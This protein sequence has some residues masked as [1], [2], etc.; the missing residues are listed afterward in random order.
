VKYTQYG[1]THDVAR[2]TPL[3]KA[4]VEGMTW[5]V[6]DYVKT[7]TDLGVD[8]LAAL[9]ALSTYYVAA[10]ESGASHVDP[11]SQVRSSQGV[12]LYPS[13]VFGWKVGLYVPDDA[14]ELIEGTRLAR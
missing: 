3:A 12:R 10:T 13:H 9:P 5:V 4:I 8:P 7:M 14:E 6:S 1:N 2:T 11:L